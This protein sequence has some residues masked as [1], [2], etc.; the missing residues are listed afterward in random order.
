MSAN[1]HWLCSARDY[2]NKDE[3]REELADSQAEIRTNTGDLEIWTHTA[4]EKPTASRPKWNTKEVSIQQN[5]S[6]E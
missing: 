4:L 3:S 6:V 1:C 5:I 2:K